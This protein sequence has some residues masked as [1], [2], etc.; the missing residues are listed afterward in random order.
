MDRQDP[1]FLLVKSLTSGERTAVRQ[2]DQKDAGYLALFD[3]ISRSPVYDERKLKKK[4][5]AAGYDINFAYAKNYLSKHILRVLRDARISSSVDGHM[6][7]IQIL[8]ERKVFVLA[9][10][11]LS[12]A[13]SAAW[14]EER[15][16][17]YLDLSK[18]QFDLSLM[19]SGNLESRISQIK[20]MN[21]KRM[22][23]RQHLLELGE[24]ED[25]YAYYR[26]V[27]K[28][29]QVARNDLDI[30]LLESLLANPLMQESSQPERV[31]AL[32]L[33]LQSRIMA[34]VYLA[35][36][37]QAMGHLEEQIAMYESHPFL[38]N[39]FPSDY[40]NDLLR[41]GGL[42]LHAGAFDQVKGILD[43]IQEFLAK[44]AMHGS[45]FFDKYYRLL[46]G[47]AI[48]SGSPALVLPAYDEILA[49]LETYRDSLSLASRMSFMALLAR[50]QFELGNYT[51]ARILLDGILLMEEPGIREDIVNIARI[52]LVFVY[53]E[54]GDLDLAESASKAARKYLRRRD[55][56]F[57][58]EKRI[59]KFL[60]AG[61]V[62]VDQSK[63]LK[64]LERDLS[65]IFQDPLEANVLALFD[66]RSW[67]AQKN[68]AMA[69]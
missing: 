48:E 56:L 6:T 10:R 44:H 18:I 5:S 34:E 40:L 60:E 46:I 69:K 54:K 49:G 1:L 39:D 3:F 68:A 9:G 52:M 67:L 38:K 8:M 36:Y 66:L 59:L 27:I 50:F 30:Q 63:A 31:R 43:R 37:G 58:F 21:T 4:I 57:K 45:E 7:E 61:L 51:E 53:W 55:Q 11:M 42:H 16:S 23:A 14:T 25:L 28:R 19:E 17:L 15:W 47:L 13:M 64:Q 65:D 35:R 32:R 41:L 22:E 2:I 20:A 29:K 12:K 33:Y 62:S 26:P 24:Y